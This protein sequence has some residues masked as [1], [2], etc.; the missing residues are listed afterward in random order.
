MLFSL[1]GEYTPQALNAM[2]GN[3]NTNR[4]AAVEQLVKAADGQVVGMYG[5]AGRGPGVLV[6]IDVPDPDM[7]VA[8][9]G[10]AVAAGTLQDVEVTRLFSMQ[11]IVQL[12]QKA[13]QLRA[14]Y[15]PPGQA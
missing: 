11:E 15:K 8:M 1:T 9:C 2:M 4:Q 13:G 5:R 3:P 10:V 7:A 6:I 14:A 12:R